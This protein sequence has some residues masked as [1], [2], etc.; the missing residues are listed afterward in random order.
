MPAPAPVDPQA[1]QL[2]AKQAA[3]ATADPTFGRFKAKATAA[4]QVVRKSRWVHNGAYCFSD[5]A[6]S[7]FGETHWYGD[8][9]DVGDYVAAD[10]SFNKGFAFLD[11]KAHV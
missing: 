2:S 10:D 7:K 5:S 4:L 11:R 6:R 8:G 9:A 1:L 3:L